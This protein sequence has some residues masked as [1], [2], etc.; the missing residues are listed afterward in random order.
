VGTMVTATVLVGL[1]MMQLRARL[2]A[3][4]FLPAGHKR[5]DDTLQVEEQLASIDSIEAIV[6]FGGRR[7]AFGEMLD[8]VRKVEAR[9]NGH[10]QVRQTVS[11]ATFFPAEL[12]GNPLAA[13]S[14]LN[15]A[16]DL[17][18]GESGYLSDFNR[19]WRISAR[20]QY[21]EKL[22]RQKVLDELQAATAEWPITFTGIAPL[23]EHA[24]TAIF[25]GFW[26]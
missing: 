20:I 5:M 10:P 2:D 1:G 24:Q 19:R 6:D 22:S 8:E 11:V 18:Q 9:L 14:V 3:L 15:Q 12:P 25:K 13:A 4:D 26:E 7:M 23:V 16:R 17:S 21:D